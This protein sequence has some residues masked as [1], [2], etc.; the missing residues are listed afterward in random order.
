MMEFKS[1]YII[2]GLL[3]L[4]AVIVIIYLVH[5]AKKTEPQNILD[6]NRYKTT[7]ATIGNKKYELKIADTKDKRKQG[8]MFVKN[9]SKDEGMLFV[10]E[11]ESIYPFWMKNTKIPL[12]IIWLDGNK[13]VVYIKKN[14]QP[15][16]NTASAI[17]K[18]IIPSKKAMY[19]IELNAGEVNKTNLKLNDY[20]NFK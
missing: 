15:C 2:I 18:S 10:F 14:A 13:K 1:T 8:L 6:I 4:I 16:Q 19:V 11:K 5:S 3:I 20:I 9:L 7:E 17:C 12:D